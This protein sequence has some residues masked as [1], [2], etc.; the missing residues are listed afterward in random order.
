MERFSDR[1]GETQPR[2]QLQAG[3]MDE[4]LRNALWNWLFWA[5]HSG[6]PQHEDYWWLAARRGM[7]DEFFHLRIDEIPVYPQNAVRDQVKE[8][9]VSVDWFEVYNFIEYVLNR[10]NNFRDR[11]DGRRDAEAGLNFVLERELSGYRA[12]QGK[13]VAVTS[14]IEVAEI[15]R[16]ATRV[17]GFEGVAEHIDTALAFLGKKPEPDCRN[18]IKES[19]SAV[20]AAVKLLTG[21]KSGGI[22]KAVA[23]LEKRGDLHSSLKLA[24]SRLYGYTSDKDGIRHPLLEESTVNFAEAKFMLVACSA[25]AN[26]LIDS[27]RQSTQ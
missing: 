8:W 1:I 13:L 6:S 17:V 9:F 10:L 23:I 14:S 27:S 19:I 2:R 25:F 12:I 16:A 18:S 5:F 4:G 7:W 21:E 3:S 20:E 11:N 26:F 15:E 22:D 24:L